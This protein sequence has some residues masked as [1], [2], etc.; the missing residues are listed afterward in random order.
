MP[1][2]AA[3]ASSPS[4]RVRKPFFTFCAGQAP[5]EWSTGSVNRASCRTQLSSASKHQLHRAPML[6]VCSVAAARPGSKACSNSSSGGASASRCQQ[7][8]RPGCRQLAATQQWRRQQCGQRR[9]G[10]A[11]AQAQPGTPSPVLS[12]RLCRSRMQSGAIISVQ[13]CWHAPSLP[14]CAAAAAETAAAAAAAAGVKLQPSPE[15]VELL[16]SADAFTFD[17]DSTL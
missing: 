9:G 1:P 8:T 6:S 16:R 4:G 7:Q 3:E 10:R 15:V 14:Y 11:M 5:P 2:S 13:H 12:D 17:V